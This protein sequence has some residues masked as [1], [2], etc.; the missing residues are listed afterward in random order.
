MQGVQ[1][2]AFSSIMSALIL[3]SLIGC[4]EHNPDYKPNQDSSV[5]CTLGQ[6]RC[7][8]DTTV[9]CL[10]S[11]AGTQY[12]AERIC[13]G[14]SSC[15][16]GICVPSGAAC[17]HICEQGQVC[18]IF[19][20]PTQKDKLDTFCASPLG[21]KAAGANCSKNAECQSGL[22]LIRAKGSICYGPCIGNVCKQGYKCT[23]VTL[24]INGVQG[25]VTSCIPS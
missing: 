19:V 18:T 17:T 13:P 5:Q 24:T 14:G 20:N 8:G 15:Q 9:V 21:L 4:T 6:R 1:R 25:Q 3:T 12:A 23:E 22:C 11:G 16:D 7:N 2:R 10:Q